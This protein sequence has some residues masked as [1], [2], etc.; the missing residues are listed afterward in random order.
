MEVIKLRATYEINTSLLKKEDVAL[1]TN[2][3][4]IDINKRSKIMPSCIY[5]GV[6]IASI[7]VQ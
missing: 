1:I 6:R 3:Y 4:L 2:E 5:Q 7:C